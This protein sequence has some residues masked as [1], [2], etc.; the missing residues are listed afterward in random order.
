M[1]SSFLEA[2]NT[3]MS[4]CCVHSCYLLFG[5]TPQNPKEI[6]QLSLQYEEG[7]LASGLET[8]VHQLGRHVLRQLVTKAPPE[9]MT[10]LGSTKVFC[11]L[12]IRREVAHAAPSSFIPKPYYRLKLARA[13]YVCISIIYGE[14]G[15]STLQIPSSLSTDE[16]WVQST[17]LG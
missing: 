6:Y 4:R 9:F 14:D 17:V 3:L 8:N 10:C 7:N 1:V 2:L 5:P 15:I 13:R 11:L 16:L 12:P